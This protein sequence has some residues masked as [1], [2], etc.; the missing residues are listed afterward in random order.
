[1][2]VIL[3]AAYV[4]ESIRLEVGKLPLSF[5]PLAN[6]RLYVFQIEALRRS[7]PSRQI[8]LTLP[9]SF[10]VTTS[11]LIWLKNNNIE[12][13]EI[14][15]SEDNEDEILQV[16]MREQLFEEQILFIPGNCLPLEYN[17]HQDMVAYIETDLEPPLQIESYGQDKDL[18]W[19]GI[20]SVSNI[21]LFIEN[22]IT[23]KNNIYRA[24]KSYSFKKKIVNV[25]LTKCYLLSNSSCYFHTRAS[26]TTERAFNTLKIE[27]T[28]L[29]KFSND[30]KKIRTEA[31]WYK[32]MPIEISKYIPKFYGEGYE[33]N[34]YYYSMEYLGI[35][36]L[37]EIF[38]YGRNTVVFWERVFSK[39]NIFLNEARKSKIIEMKRGATKESLFIKKANKRLEE[40]VNQTGFDAES[41]LE[42]NDVAVPSLKKIIEEA[43]DQI[44]FLNEVPAFIHG[45]LCLSNI[46]YDSRMRS[47]K[48]IDPRG[49]DENGKMMLRGS[50]IYDIAKLGHS[51]IGLYD[52]IIA[53]RFEL[54]VLDNKFKLKIYIEDDIEEIQNAFRKHSI[55]HDIEMSRLDKILPLLF[56]S[57]L[58]LH[59]DSTI[60]QQA[61]LANAL[62][63]YAE[64]NTNGV[65]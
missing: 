31:Y 19:T 14:E 61:L 12:I 7:Y 46:L 26:F 52:H 18:V 58:P 42:I 5:V 43:S 65:E 47:V 24:L 9:F 49:N 25:V 51:I 3:S 64:S 45:D 35:I 36:P 28:V 10:R 32:N 16:L 34:K 1:M 22:L 11:E 2:I 4:L 55:M 30:Q 50:Q 53:D 56:I 54:T 39:I 8:K 21:K 27:N 62:R 13:I 38:V 40:F 59:S 44:I 57:M 33:N 6:R 20:F 29:K 17:D 63:I 60:R 23:E 37:N 41:P 48:L 15:S